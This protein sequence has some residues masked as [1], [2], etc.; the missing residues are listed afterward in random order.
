MTY[1]LNVDDKWNAQL[2]LSLAR[3][4]FDAH[5]NS[6]LNEFRKQA[7]I[8]GFRPGKVPAAIVQQKFSKEI[9]TET[10]EKL[11][12]EKLMD[13][14]K[15][16]QLKVISRP[17]VKN[18]DKKDEEVEFEIV[19]DVF[20]EITLEHY[21][22]IKINL[23][24]KAADE[25]TV[26]ENLKALLNM[27][28]NIE[29]SDE[30]LD[31]GMIAICD[32][33]IFDN[34]GKEL[35]EL[36]S[37]D[38][39]IELGSA[40]VFPEISKNLKGKK[41]N[42]TV[43]FEFKYPDEY[44][45]NELKGKEVKFRIDVKHTKKRILPEANDEFA[46]KLGVDSYDMLRDLTKKRLENDFNRDFD[47]KKEER[48]VDF[49]IEKNPFNAPQ[50]L[51]ITHLES[52]LR[53]LKKDEDEVTEEM[54]NM[55]KGYAEWRAKREVMLTRLIDQEKIEVKDEEIHEEIEKMKKSPNKNVR[56]FAASEDA[57]SSVHDELLFDK[58]RKFL[59]EHTTIEEEKEENKGGE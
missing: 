53:S 32:I 8:D 20:P 43:E 5:Y 33:F 12:P 16:K 3:S 49:L 15:E 1:N 28:A 42:D 51:V 54:V 27:Y 56:E 17:Y 29:D 10:V 36:R 24:K 38:F 13:V 55:Y 26:D 59:E 46:K 6:V 7:K 58:A 34:E 50:S 19:F 23:T 18:V 57:H 44:D 4:E 47:L 45:D 30:A 9:E 35:E 25:K 48:I 22:D 11:L 41:A 21:N 2:M 14:I 37:L 52:V 40:Y 39:S 31:D